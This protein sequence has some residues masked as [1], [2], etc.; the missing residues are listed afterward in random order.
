ME[1]SSILIRFLSIILTTLTK[2]D[3]KRITESAITRVNKKNC[4]QSF[5]SLSPIKTQKKYDTHDNMLLCSR[6][7][8]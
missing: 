3:G 4:F 6:Y 7:A 2:I 8:V 1:K 5:I